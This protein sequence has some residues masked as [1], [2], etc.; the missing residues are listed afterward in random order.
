MPNVAFAIS[1][2][3]LALTTSHYSAHISMGL[4]LL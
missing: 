1:Q 4:Q 3:A 2:I